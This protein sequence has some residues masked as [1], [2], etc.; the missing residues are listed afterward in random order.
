MIEW[1]RR[2]IHDAQCR[3]PLAT[4]RQQDRVRELYATRRPLPPD[5]E[6][7]AYLRRSRIVGCH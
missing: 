3:P 4:R 7:P 2:M 5:Y 1:L 6:R